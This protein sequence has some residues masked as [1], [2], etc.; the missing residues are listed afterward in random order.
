MA[1]DVASEPNA[2]GPYRFAEPQQE[3]RFYPRRPD[4]ERT[5]AILAQAATWYGGKVGVV[6]DGRVVKPGRALLVQEAI[7]DMHQRQRDVAWSGGIPVTLMGGAA[8][9]TSPEGVQ[10][11]R[12]P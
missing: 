8:D 2:G 6:I 3:C 7:N 4:P 10:P 12:M 9:A 11:E 5:A 1:A